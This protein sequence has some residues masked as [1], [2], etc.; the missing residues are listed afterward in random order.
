MKLK[1][2]SINLKKVPSFANFTQRQYDY[3]KLEKQLLGWDNFEDNYEI[4]DI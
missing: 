4:D 3:D 2:I 1:K